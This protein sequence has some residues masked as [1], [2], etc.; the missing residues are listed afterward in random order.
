MYAYI[1]YT[2]LAALLTSAFSANARES[3]RDRRI[4]DDF[5][6]RSQLKNVSATGLVFCEQSNH[7]AANTCALQFK[8][9]SDEKIFNI[10][11]SPALLQ[12]HM[13][14]HKTLAVSLKGRVVRRLIFTN[15]NLKV[16]QFNVNRRTQKDV[17]AEINAKREAERKKRRAS[18]DSFRSRSNRW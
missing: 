9:D 14:D 4:G 16:S 8:R 2:V 1:K 10:V 12:D 6:Q 17:V 18:N 5:G 13:R 7:R 3:L 15:D 11:E